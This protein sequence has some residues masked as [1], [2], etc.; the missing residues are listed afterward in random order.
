MMLSPGSSVPGLSILSLSLSSQQQNDR[1]TELGLAQPSLGI[2]RAERRLTP[3]FFSRVSFCLP[4][5]RLLP[6]LD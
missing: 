4:D 2:S 5:R 3:P 6:P 1:E